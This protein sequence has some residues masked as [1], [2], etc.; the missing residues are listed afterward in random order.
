MPIEPTLGHKNDDVP[1][2]KGIS[3]VGHQ[4][5]KHIF[6]YAKRPP[7]SVRFVVIS[8][9][10]SIAIL[11]GLWHVTSKF[12]TSF[13][14]W[15]FHATSKFQPSI[16]KFLGYPSHSKMRSK[17]WYAVCLLLQLFLEGFVFSCNK[18]DLSFNTT[19]HNPWIVLG[20]VVEGCHSMNWWV[21]VWEDW[22]EES[23]YLHKTRR[24]PR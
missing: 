4:S 21:R 7:S 1:T 15:N 24:W 12:Y 14:L 16:S 23:H 6:C 17:L 11:F 19:A 22:R 2:K 5:L 3:L 10:L 13:F 20:L 9:D 8:W 18:K